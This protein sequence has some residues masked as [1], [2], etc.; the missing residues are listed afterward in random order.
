MYLHLVKS[1]ATIRSIFMNSDAAA[2]I[3]KEHN[4]IHY[5]QRNTMRLS[6][7]VSGISELKVFHGCN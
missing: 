6:M 3:Q 1:V 7:L 2:I 4:N 5:T